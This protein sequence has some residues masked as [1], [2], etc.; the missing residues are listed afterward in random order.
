MTKSYI[1]YR[2][3]FIDWDD[4]LGDWASSAE[5]AQRTLWE[6]HN[7]SEWCRSF[8]EWLPFYR[9]HNDDLWAAYSRNEITR[10]YLHVDQFLY[11]IC[12]YLG[13]S[14]ES[15]PRCLRD[16][17]KRMG[18][19]Y[20]ELTN[21]YFCLVEGAAE[22]VRY[23][24][25]KYPVTI[26][27]NGYCE[28]QYLKLRKSGLEPYVRYTVF[29]E[30]AGVMKPDPRIFEIAIARHADL[31]PNLK[32]EEVIMIG[33]GYGSDI[34]GARAAGIDTIWFLRHEESPERMAEATYTVTNLAQVKD[35]L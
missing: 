34:T 27:S 11:P 4:T 7:L 32:P 33:D 3:V 26:V 13:L 5:R 30:E 15:A 24:A 19:E 1:K 16:L 9:A 29:S 31:L 8:E 25:D 18:D 12:H 17:A 35:I 23:L 20:I 21:E 22:M 28:T 10:D 14:T 6:R 2:A